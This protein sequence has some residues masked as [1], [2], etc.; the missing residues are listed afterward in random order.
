MYFPIKMALKKK[1]FE[2]ESAPS[3][4][5]FTQETTKHCTTTVLPLLRRVY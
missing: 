3:K 2:A 5:F 1:S 4:G